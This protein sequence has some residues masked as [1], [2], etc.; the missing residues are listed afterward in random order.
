MS[1]LF[2]PRGTSTVR[3]RM[4]VTVTVACALATGA[5]SAVTSIEAAAMKGRAWGVGENRLITSD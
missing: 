2:E 5:R 1:S 3:P 4:S